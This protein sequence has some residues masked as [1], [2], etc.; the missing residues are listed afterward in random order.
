M[1]NRANQA[2]RH[3][4]RT[5]LPGRRHADVDHRRQQP[6]HLRERGLHRRQRVRIGRGARASPQRRAPRGHAAGNLRRHVG[7]AEGGR[8]V[9][10]T[11]QE[12]PQERRPHYGV[13]ANTTPVARNGQAVGYMSVRTR[14][15]RDEVAAAEKLCA[16]FNAGQAGNRAFHK[17]LLVRPRLMRKS[18]GQWSAWRPRPARSLRPH[19]QQPAPEPG[20][21][22]RHDA[23]RHQP[24]RPDVPVGR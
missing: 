21:R 22:D 18:H 12:P 14:P 5:R 16:E 9:D 23:A 17:G 24:A 19:A 7:H 2:S 4:A 13:R 6:H 3:P 8:I 1:P 11:G 15:G 10:G 20:R